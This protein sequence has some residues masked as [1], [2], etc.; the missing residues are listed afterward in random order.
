MRGD[1]KSGRPKQRLAVLELIE[2]DSA[3]DNQAG[4]VESL[5]GILYLYVGS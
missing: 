3:N 1:H 2:Q 4:A 5:D